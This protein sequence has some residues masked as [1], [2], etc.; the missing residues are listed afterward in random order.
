MRRA[1]VGLALHELHK[2]RT[3][4]MKQSLIVVAG[5]TGNLGGR[6]IHA[7]LGRGATVRAL[8]RAGSDVD[9]IR[10]LR[11]EGVDAVLVNYGDRQSLVAACA[12][13]SCVVSALSGLRDVVVDAQSALLDAAVDAR[14]DRFIP[15]DFCIDYNRLEPGGNRNLDLRREFSQR[16]NRAPI[17]ATSI[18]NGAFT[19]MLTGQAP[20]ILFKRRRVL[21]WGSADQLMDFT[22][23]DD[24]AEF[25]AAAALDSATPRWL[26]IAGDEISARGIARVVSA[27]TGND[28]RLRKAGPLGLLR[29][30]TAVAKVV[31]PRRN[32][33]Y[34][35]WQGMQYLHDMFGGKAKLH[36]LDNARYGK[37]QWTTVGDVLTS[38]PV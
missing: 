29:T 16:L 37:W 23:R 33:L 2:T 26:R 18:L 30:L 34:P 19:D 7:L 32:D 22:T 12:G 17:A 35:P 36:P 31:A 27:V 25:T 8:I 38:R 28:F 24:T 5:A 3:Q 6:I 1:G 4:R 14:V 10:L 20:I 9:A 11:D 13:A 15:S 21:Y